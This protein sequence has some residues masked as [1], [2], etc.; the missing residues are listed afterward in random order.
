MHN[1]KGLKCIVGLF[2]VALMIMCFSFSASADD[3]KPWA[4]AQVEFSSK[5]VWRGFELSKDSLMIFPE[6]TVGYKGFWADIWG[7]YDTDVKDDEVYGKGTG[8]DDWEETDFSLGY[9]YSYK[10]LNFE[11]G[12]YYYDYDYPDSPG[13]NQEVYLQVSYDWVIT[14]TLT[15]Y[16]EIER[17]DNWY[18]IL[19]LSYTKEFKNGWSV[20]AAASASWMK[21]DD[22]DYDAMHNSQLDLDLNIPFAKYF[23]ITPAIHY[24]FPL[25]NDAED[26]IKSWSYN[27]DDDNFFW[28][29]VTL[30]MSF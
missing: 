26:L 17:G 23:T 3:D 25:S 24:S 16:K 9:D 7:A 8:S 6:M 18:A 22:E 30:S 27:G 11:L 15:V 21:L 2:M 13:S 5:Y 14:P 29:G 1:S 10:N 20:D 19:K 28:G 12:W 4:T